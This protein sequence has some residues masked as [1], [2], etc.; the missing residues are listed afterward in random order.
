MFDR[1]NRIWG[2]MTQRDNKLYVSIPRKQIQRMSKTCFRGKSYA[3]AGNF[4]LWGT[5]KEFLKDEEVVML[6]REQFQEDF[7][8]KK[9]GTCSCTIELE[10][11]VGWSSTLEQ[12]ECAGTDLALETRPLNNRATATFVANLEA[13]VTYHITVK[14]KI[15][16]ADET[17]KVT[18]YSLYPGRDVGELE[19]NVSAREDVYFLDWDTPGV[20]KY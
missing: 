16:S 20:E 12:S 13:P 3:L 17:A 9:S 7:L 8:Q 1:E 4:S 6:L 19:G 10:N 5:A 2:L 18:I 15:E 11:P 14:Y